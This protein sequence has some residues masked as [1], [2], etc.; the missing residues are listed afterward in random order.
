MTFRPTDDILDS[1][2][3][4][5]QPQATSN[6]YTQTSDE[7]VS[8]D[9]NGSRIFSNPDADENNSNIVENVNIISD[10]PVEE[11]KAPDLSQLLENSENAKNWGETTS[12]NKVTEE[13]AEDFTVDLS[14]IES[15]KLWESAA[16]DNTQSLQPQ[17]GVSTS[18]WWAKQEEEEAIPWKM[19][20]KERE[21]IISWMEGSI[22]SK[23]D[24]LVDNEWK[25]VVENIARFIVFCL[26]GELLFLL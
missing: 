13:A 7:S 5:Q 18:D 1:M 11:V 12:V 20:D 17:S 23:L 4:S 21:E 14:E 8:N 19:L 22:H 6:Q 16:G 10:T 3:N 9:S 15:D 26:D 2:E 24:L 25:S